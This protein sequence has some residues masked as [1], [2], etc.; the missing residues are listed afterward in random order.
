M[1]TEMKAFTSSCSLNA[2][3]L[4]IFCLFYFIIYLLS[5]VFQKFN[6]MNFFKKIILINNEKG[7]KKKFV[8]CFHLIRK[9]FSISL[10]FMSTFSEIK[11]Y[12]LI[13]L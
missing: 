11:P 12:L 2:L 8:H 10:S 13:V 4:L 1:S 5:Q 9:I 3:F 6:P 7:I